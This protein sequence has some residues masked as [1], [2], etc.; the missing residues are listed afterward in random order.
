MKKKYIPDLIVWLIISLVFYVLTS[1][2]LLNCYYIAHFWN[3]GTLE[4]HLL[5]RKNTEK[6][7]RKKNEKEIFYLRLQ[8]WTQL[9]FL[10]RI[11]CCGVHF[12][13][14]TY[15][16]L[17]FQ[18]K[19]SLLNNEQ[20]KNDNNIL[21]A[22]TCLWNSTIR[23][24]WMKLLGEIVKEFCH[25]FWITYNKRK[26]LPACKAASQGAVGLRKLEGMHCCL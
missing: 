5:E 15:V 14:F 10:F 21:I 4:I 20:A 13:F 24:L 23:L 25:L 3:S 19:S 8:L 6:K 1:G 11:L 17:W 2:Y 16:S 22:Y 26:Y 7:K 12:K 18:T 9:C